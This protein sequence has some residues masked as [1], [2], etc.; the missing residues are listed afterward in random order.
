MTNALLTFGELRTVTFEIE[1][2]LNLRPLTCTDDD[3][4]NVILAPN[5]LIYTRNINDKCFDYN[6][7]IDMGKKGVQ[8]S[9][10]HMKLVLKIFFNQFENK[11]ISALKKTS[12]LWQQTLQ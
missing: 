10:A 2:K 6:V 4:D 3:T 9:F 7:T 11:Y 5:Y 12:Y 8:S 1:G